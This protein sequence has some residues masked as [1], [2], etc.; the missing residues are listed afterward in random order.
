MEADMKRRGADV[1]AISV[2]AFNHWESS[3]RAI[4]RATRWFEELASK[5]PGN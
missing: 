4:P 1:T 2:G 3:L 5:K